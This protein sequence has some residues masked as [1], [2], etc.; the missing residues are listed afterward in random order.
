MINKALNVAPQIRYQSAEE[1]RHALEHQ[2]LQVD[3]T[4][5]VAPTKSV[6]RGTDAS[7]VHYDVVKTQ[8][9]NHKWKVETRRGSSATALR[10]IGNLC[11]PEMRKK[12][13]ADK[14]ARRILQD[15]VTGKA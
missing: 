3:W 4:E 10:R 5:S 6:S 15:F 8:Q 14:K 7:S 13:D 9:N 11:F 1:M 12:Q 2:I